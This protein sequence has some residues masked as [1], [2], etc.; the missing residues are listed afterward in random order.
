[1]TQS[2]YRPSRQIIIIGGAGGV[3]KTSIVHNLIELYAAHSRRSILVFNTGD[4]FSE[5][6]GDSA[7]I[8]R[9]QVKNTYW[10]KYEQEVTNLIIEDLHKLQNSSIYVLDTHFAANSPS[11]YMMGLGV[12]QIEYLAKEINSINKN[13]VNSVL[14]AIVLIEADIENVISR[15]SSETTSQTA[16]KKEREG[17]G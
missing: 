10:K 2:E 7:P 6:L 11:G 4:Y 17:P 14:A 15:R 8:A 12:K 9:D 3:G 13:S 1:V 16:E 5:L